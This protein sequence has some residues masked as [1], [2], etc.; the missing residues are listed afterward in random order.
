MS[1]DILLVDDDPKV[2][3][4]VS[5]SLGR[6]GYRVRTAATGREALQHA[7]EATPHL[8]ILDLELPDMSG[9]DVLDSIRDDHE[10]IPVLVLSAQNDVETR[11]AAL[12]GGADEYIHKPVSL[13]ELHVRVDAALRRTSRAR[14]LDHRNIELESE[15]EHEREEVTRVERSFK[16]HMLSMR[17]LLTVSQDLNRAQQPD[18]LIKTASL[19]L[20]GELRVSSLAIFG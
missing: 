5:V 12:D 16:R 6:Q 10:T 18:E 19:T 20:V 4:I 13:R 1:A 3:E 11:V 8:M 9:I 7:A 15:I 2:L 17:T 14:S